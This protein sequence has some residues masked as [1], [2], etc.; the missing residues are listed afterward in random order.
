[1]R[2]FLRRA[3]VYTF[4]AIVVIGVMAL[5]IFVFWVVAYSLSVHYRRQAEG[6]VQQLVTI[7]E[8][9][10]TT[11]TLQ[12]MAKDYGE[13]EHCTADSCTYDFDRRFGFTNSGAV[14]RP[15]SGTIWDCDLGV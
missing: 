4:H 14:I 13:K 12:K 6:L 10:A 8:V 9:G 2:T 3:C 11:S 7:D 5:I 15:T 1:M